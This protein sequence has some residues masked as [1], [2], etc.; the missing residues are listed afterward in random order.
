MGGE[1]PSGPAELAAEEAVVAI[2]VT[3]VAVAIGLAGGKCRAG[4][5]PRAST[6]RLLSRSKNSGVKDGAARPVPELY[7]SVLPVP[8]LAVEV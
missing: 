3:P 8:G 7:S 5:P 1:P 6:L 2:A 4:A